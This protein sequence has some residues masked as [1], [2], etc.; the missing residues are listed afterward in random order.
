MRLLLQSN[1]AVKC[2]SWVIHIVFNPLRPDPGKW[3]YTQTNHW[4]E[5][6]NC[7]SVMEH[8][9]GVRSSMVNVDIIFVC[10]IFI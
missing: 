6:T 2:Y 8:L 7:L 9:G 5:P 1:L 4:Q 3:S 10:P